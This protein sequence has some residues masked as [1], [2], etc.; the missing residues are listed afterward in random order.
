[1]QRYL[2]TNKLFKLKVHTTLSY[3]KKYLEHK[4]FL[5]PFL[6]SGFQASF[7]FFFHFPLETD[8]S[9]RIIDMAQ[10]KVFNSL[11]CQVWLRCSGVGLYKIDDNENSKGTKYMF[12]L[13]LCNAN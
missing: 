8:L 9:F 10:W 2:S 12:L 13:Y 6:K 3:S 4:Y 11:K 1:M 7:F 5:A